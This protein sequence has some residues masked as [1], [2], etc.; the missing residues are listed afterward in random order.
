MLQA[1]VD[2]NKWFNL[3]LA[4]GLREPSLREIQSH[5]SSADHKREMLTKWLNQVDGCL[6]SWRGLIDSL[7]SPT[8]QAYALASRLERDLGGM[9]CDLSP[10]GSEHSISSFSSSSLM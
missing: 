8:V 1:L 3:G 2:L 6:P 7:R 9:E 10:Q 4:L 5:H